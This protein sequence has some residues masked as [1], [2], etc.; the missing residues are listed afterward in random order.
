MARWATVCKIAD[1][2][3]TGCRA[4]VV[5]GEPFLSPVAGSV[6][7]ANDNKP[8]IQVFD[9]GVEGIQFGIT[10]AS[11]Q[12]SKIEDAVENINAAIST[13]A[14]FEVEID[15]GIYEIAVN[16]FPDFSQKWYVAGK[17]SEGWYEGITWR[18]V[19]ESAMA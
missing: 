15:D 17:H 14:T 16:C 18:F 7:W 11:Q 2:T 19:S 8:H 9:R 3:F 5:D 12:I 6:E 4:E 10:M 1:I 13:G